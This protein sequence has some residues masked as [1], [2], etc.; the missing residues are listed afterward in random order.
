MKSNF[1][2]Q[3]DVLEELHWTPTLN[4]SQ[5]GVTV[6]NGIVTLRGSV[7]SYSKKK[8]AE[9]AVQRVGGVKAIADELLVQFD[10]AGD[11]SSDSEIA[12]EIATALKT[13]IIIPPGHVKAVVDHGRVNLEG[14]VQWHYQQEAAKECIETLRGI[15]SINNHIKINPKVN[16]IVDKVAVENALDRN[17]LVDNDHIRVE[18]NDHKVILKGTVKTWFQKS[19][20]ER[21][22]WAAPGV[23]SVEND[24]VVVY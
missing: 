1:Q 11:A 9:H 16:K 22:A 18:T 5:I 13:N 6:E 15:R 19:E 7:D 24:L 4:A 12:A 8:I 3:K 20:A 10:H 2:I 17:S 21:V 23:R 14:E